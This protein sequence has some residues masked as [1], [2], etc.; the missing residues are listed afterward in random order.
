MQNIMD[1]LFTGQVHVDL[2]EDSCMCEGEN[3]RINQITT[4]TEY[5][6]YL[7]AYIVYSDDADEFLF[8][9]S[10]DYIKSQLRNENDFY[11]FDYRRRNGE[12]YN[13]NRLHIIA[14]KMN[15]NCVPV[16]II[17]VNMDI[18][19]IKKSEY[20]VHEK[21]VKANQAKSDFLSNVSHDLRTPMNAIMGFITLL[22]HDVDKPDR[23]RNDIRKLQASSRHMLSVIN[24]VLDMNK[25]E[26]RVVTINNVEFELSS[27][28][29]DVNIVTLQLTKDKRQ[30]FIMELKDVRNNW[31]V[32]DKDRLSQI[33]MNILSNAV[34]YTPESGE[35]KLIISQ[36]SN[37]EEAQLQ[38]EVRDNGI[39]M[40]PEFIDRIFEPFAREEHRISPDVM[41]TGLGMSITR[42]LIDLMDGE[43]YV[44][45]KV[46]EGSSFI[47]RINFEIGENHN[48]ESLKTENCVREPGVLKGMNFLV[49]E[50]NATNGDIIKGLMEIEGAYTTVCGD[51]RETVDT[52]IKSPPYTFDM[53]L[54]DIRMPKMNGY[55]AAKAIRS[56]GIDGSDI[57][58]I[59]AMTANVFSEDI[60]EA[61][62]AG[63]NGHIPKPID[64]EVLKSTIKKNKLTD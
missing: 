47:V 42:S 39:G 21:M 20:A 4:F 57:I 58:P 7:V 18:D 30:N 15:S 41:G 2:A 45:S 62:K 59:L 48:Y 28:L 40:E 12:I 23:L 54:M 11:C 1:K 6:R 19:K 9:C 50:D 44:K 63:M 3:L 16:K 32:G 38:F 5:L 34:K 14:E 17:L 37:T 13:W 55:E 56:S 10:M 52:F 61:I 49:A 43:I 31:I 36:S 26:N 8:K 22:E 33:L 46:N 25:I 64:F 35:I 53:I 24:D 60:E 27:F 29:E 51:G